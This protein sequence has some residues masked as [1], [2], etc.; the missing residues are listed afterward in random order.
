M[1]LKPP[2]RATVEELPMETTV[3]TFSG[4]LCEGDRPAKALLVCCSRRG[5]AAVGRIFNS[6]SNFSSSS[7]Y[8]DRSSE[9]RG[10]GEIVARSYARETHSWLLESRMRHSISLRVQRTH[11]GLLLS[12]LTFF[13]EHCL[14]A[15]SR[16]ICRASVAMVND[17]RDGQLYTSS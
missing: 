5:A 11:F 16:G 7:M 3:C 15:G 4:L 9:M 17:Y 14:H 13:W 12:H 1:K 8:L 2:P 6:S 10:C